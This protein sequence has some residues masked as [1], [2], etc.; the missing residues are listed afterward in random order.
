MVAIIDKVLIVLNS[1]SKNKRLMNDPVHSHHSSLILRID[2]SYDDE[3]DL[4]DYNKKND[5]HSPYYYHHCYS[6]SHPSPHRHSIQHSGSNEDL[7]EFLNQNICIKFK[8]PTGHN[9]KSLPSNLLSCDRSRKQIKI[10]EK[11]MKQK[12]KRQRRKSFFSSLEDAE[13]V[14][15]M[16]VLKKHAK[17]WNDGRWQPPKYDIDLKGDSHSFLSPKLSAMHSIKQRRHN[18]KNKNYKTRKKGPIETGRAKGFK[19]PKYKLSDDND[20][21]LETYRSW[22]PSTNKSVPHLKEKATSQRRKTTQIT[23]A[24]HHHQKQ[25]HMHR[26]SSTKSC[27]SS[28]R[29]DDDHLSFLMND[30]EQYNK[31]NIDGMVFVTD[32]DKQRRRNSKSPKQ[33]LKFIHSNNIDFLQEKSCLITRK[34]SSKYARDRRSKT[35][36]SNLGEQLNGDPLLKKHRNRSKSFK[37]RKRPSST[38]RLSEN[39]RIGALIEDIDDFRKRTRSKKKRTSKK[40]YDTKSS[41]KHKQ[42]ETESDSDLYDDEYDF[43]IDINIDIDI[44]VDFDDEEDIFD[45]VN[46]YKYSMGFSNDSISVQSEN[47]Q[48]KLN[49]SSRYKRSDDEDMPQYKSRKS[50]RILPRSQ[51]D[52]GY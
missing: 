51:S 36:C 35:Y 46:E 30:H 7:C 43:D 50:S 1:D 33:K 49:E 21:F 4:N 32:Y 24:K 18:E 3:E 28:Y 26:T 47:E 17:R 6:T 38:K 2:S 15:A 44:D 8:S 42:N 16:K 29:F 45:I 23:K 37:K 14:N 39:D 20:L 9:R 52:Y 40:I 5:S 13:T 27:N 11:K 48:P 41:S 10:K 34:K 22:Y 31:N 19:P 25:K 12:Y